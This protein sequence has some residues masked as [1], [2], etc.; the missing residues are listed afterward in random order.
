MKMFIQYLDYGVGGGSMVEP[1][2]DRSV[3]IVDGRCSFA[4]AK[5]IARENNG[6]CRPK[7]L[8]F[9]IYN[10]DFKHSSFM[11]EEIF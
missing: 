1:C 3:V 6:H 2:G 4:S 7:Y 8:G 10:G 5:I 9:R 11:Y